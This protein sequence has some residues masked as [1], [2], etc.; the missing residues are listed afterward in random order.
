[1]APEATYALLSP[2]FLPA[3]VLAPAGGVVAFQFQCQRLFDKTVEVERR[4]D[5]IHVNDRGKEGKRPRGA[6]GEE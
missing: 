2:N 5:Q 6:A 1:M 3:L 4:K